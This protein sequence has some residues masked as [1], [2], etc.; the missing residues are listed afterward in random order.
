[1]ST[2]SRKSVFLCSLLVSIRLCNNY[3]NFLVHH[4]LSQF[5]FSTLEASLPAVATAMLTGVDRCTIIFAYFIYSIYSA[6]FFFCLMKLRGQKRNDDIPNAHWTRNETWYSETLIWAFQMNILDKKNRCPQRCFLICNCINGL[7]MYL[8][9]LKSCQGENRSRPGHCK[10]HFLLRFRRFA[11]AGPGYVALMKTFLF[12][13]SHNGGQLLS[14]SSLFACKS[15]FQWTAATHLLAV[16]DGS[17]RWACLPAPSA[18]TGA[19][20][21]LGNP[22]KRRRAAV[23][24]AD[25]A[26]VVLC[27]SAAQ[28]MQEA[29]F[30]RFHYMLL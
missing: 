4:R 5:F 24:Q 19:V 28:L 6:S 27:A 1:M 7:S 2:D 15:R 23:T 20:R 22:G 25:A 18:I 21:R 16:K 9:H 10:T 13:V 3:V 26:P 8:C 30:L 29:A 17:L 11:T 12:C 14:A